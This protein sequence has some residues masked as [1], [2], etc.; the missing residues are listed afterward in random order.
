MDEEIKY[1]N[2]LIFLGIVLIISIIMVVITTPNIDGYAIRN[3]KSSTSSIT[4]LDIILKPVVYGNANEDLTQTFPIGQMFDLDVLFYDDQDIG[5]R[6]IQLNVQLNRKILARINLPCETQGDMILCGDRTWNAVKVPTGTNVYT[7]KVT[8]KDK[9]GNFISNTKE[10]TLTF[11]SVNTGLCKELIPKYNKQTPSKI[12][13]VFLGFGYDNI[14]ALKL[15]ANS[16]LDLD[17]NNYGLFSVEPFKK[18]KNKFNFW[19]ISTLLPLPAECVSTNAN[20]NILNLSI[21]ENCPYGNKYIVGLGDGIFQS[22]SGDRSVAIS[23]PVSQDLPLDDESTI[24][25]IFVHE[26]GG[27]AFGELGDEYVV[28][29]DE[30]YEFESDTSIFADH[31]NCYAGPQ[32]TMEECFQNA[33]W[34]DYIG[35][36]CGKNR[37]ID[38]KEGDRNYNLE[39]GCFEGCNKVGLGIFRPTINSIMNQFDTL[40]YSFGVWNEKLIRDEF[41]VNQQN[42]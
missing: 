23:V 21:A 18:N 42:G 10:F 5:I 29:P 32:H 25:K 4:F 3:K 40:P 41:L 16:M 14:E 1:K 11:K 13:M 19:Y 35:N 9:L 15:I 31:K 2:N 22:N 8:G 33:P 34:K 20:C 17:A 26:F 6:N 28:Y 36:G 38:C 39:I 24:G 37:V 30:Q 27:H 7:T 12:N